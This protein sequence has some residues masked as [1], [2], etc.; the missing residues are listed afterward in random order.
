MASDGK[1]D[2]VYGDLAAIR[3]MINES[4]EFKLMLQTPAIAPAVK[5]S[6]L[7]SICVKAGTDKSVINFL[8][9]L[10][11]NKRL[12]CLS[13][14]IELYETFYRAEKGLVP[15]EVTSAKELSEAERGQVKSAMQN[16]AE[17]GSTLIMEY[18]V[19]PMLYGGLVVKLGEMVF[20]QSVQ[21]RLERL[22]TQLL[23]PVV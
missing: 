12:S 4:A 21:T 22:Q 9:V 6:V 18:K 8:K 7:E 14:I 19:N 2:Q 20:D 3:D 23:A 1:L 17:S 5:V 15:C 10:I 13:Q 11:E 16:R